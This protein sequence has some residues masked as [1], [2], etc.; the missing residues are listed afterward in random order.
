[1][2]NILALLFCL[3]S[4]SGF[5]QYYQNLS[6]LQRAPGY[7]YTVQTDS[8]GK[9]IYRAIEN[10]FGGSPLIQA[11]FDSLYVNSGGTPIWMKTE[12]EDG[13]S[14]NIIAVDAAQFQIDSSGLILLRA[15]TGTGTAES[16][17]RLSQFQ[18]T[19]VVLEH[20][21][22]ADAATLTLD[23]DGNSGISAISVRLESETARVI[24]QD[25]TTK[26]TNE[27]LLSGYG[28]DRDFF[29]GVT[30]AILGVDGTGT[31]YKVDPDSLGGTGGGGAGIYSPGSGALASNVD[32]NFSSS[33]KMSFNN[34]GTGG[35]S[36][37]EFNDSTLFGSSYIGFKRTG[38]EVAQITW[39]STPVRGLRFASSGGTG[40]QTGLIIGNGAW[41]IGNSLIGGLT[42]GFD[43]TINIVTSKNFIPIS[44]PLE[45]TTSTRLPAIRPT[46]S[47]QFW[48]HNTDGTG[49]Y[50]RPGSMTVTNPTGGPDSLQAALQNIY[51]AIPTQVNVGGIS[52]LAT[53]SASYTAVV[54]GDTTG[55]AISLPVTSG[56]KSGITKEAAQSGD[57]I[58]VAVGGPAYFE[59]SAFVNLAA[60]AD[61][62]RLEVY[63]NNSPIYSGLYAGIPGNG[64]SIR[65]AS[66]SFI[67]ELQNNDVVTIKLSS[68][69][70]NTVSILSAALTVKKI[71]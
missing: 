70:A 64:T 63:A 61:D 36:Y 6:T 29:G 39:D 53:S 58:R 18:A 71:Q 4:F 38:A 28:A 7:A 68:S 46:G 57:G 66:L 9:Q 44:Y 45:P 55:N 47:N 43:S 14:V 5:G 52:A 40:A 23:G 8:A 20:L 3:V 42:M 27:L 48:R 26:I 10:P 37:F 50:I 59:I 35:N 1:M 19:P 25:T 56:V 11:V 31:V 22:G 41:V 16:F 30:P 51:D 60:N 2:K 17:L 49:Q 67:Q 12:L 24:V 34:T 32:V 21:V 13:T 54:Y 15:R 69:D 65:S 33:R 62:F